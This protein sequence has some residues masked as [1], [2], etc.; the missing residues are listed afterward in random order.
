MQRHEPQMG[1]ACLEDRR[2]AAIAVDPVQQ[3]RSLG[4][5]AVGGRC[6]EMDPLSP[7][8][9]RHHLHRPVRVDSPVA[10]PKPRHAAE[11]GGKK[12][13]MPA[14]Q[15]VR[16]DGCVAVRGGVEHHLDHAFHVPVNRS[17]RT[18]IE[19]ELAATRRSPILAVYD[20]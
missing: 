3:M 9:A 7:D 2:L 10:H 8:G 18:D 15:A 1:Q 5:E 17:E 19:S 20:R 16:G 11:T 12:R 14:E 4:V 6:F 13:R